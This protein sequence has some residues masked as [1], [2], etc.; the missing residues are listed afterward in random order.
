MDNVENLKITVPENSTRINLVLEL[1]KLIPVERETVET[2]IFCDNETAIKFNDEMSC[3]LPKIRDFCISPHPLVCLCLSHYDVSFAEKYIEQLVDG[4]FLRGFC[5]PY[6]ENGNPRVAYEPLLL[7][8][9]ILNFTAVSADTRFL[10]DR[11]INAHIR[12]ILTL[13]PQNIT[14]AVTLLYLNEK[15]HDILGDRLFTVQN[16]TALKSVLSGSHFFSDW[17]CADTA[18]KIFDLSQK[19]KLPPCFSYLYVLE[20]IYG[21]KLQNNCVG[22]YPVSGKLASMTVN[23]NG[24]KIFVNYVQGYPKKA[25]IGNIGYSGDI[26]IDS[27]PDD[28]IQVTVQA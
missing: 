10:R 1:D 9:C 16:V 23:L 15:A 19:A 18:K 2:P 17:F 5:Y 7:T 20:K 13:P 8:A 3:I 24:K 28:Y 12:K 14:E 6:F 22:F 25:Y 27:L 11:E 26:K 4:G 21:V